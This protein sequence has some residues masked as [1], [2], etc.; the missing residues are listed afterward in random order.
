MC[1]PRTSAC[2][3]VVQGQ[4]SV[5]GDGGLPITHVQ[6]RKESMMRSLLLQGAISVV[7]AAEMMGIVS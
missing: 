3:G 6:P 2:V 5:L 1:R 7:R 4:Q